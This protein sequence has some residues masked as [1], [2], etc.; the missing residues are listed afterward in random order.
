V[1]NPPVLTPAFDPLGIVAALAFVG[2]L[3]YLFYWMFHVPPPLP[4]EVVQAQFSFSA[5][6]RIIV[7]VSGTVASDRAIEL[8]SRI[9]AAQR[10]E[11]VP[12]FVVEV[13]LTLGLDASLPVQQARASEVL[14]RAR[15]LVAVHHLPVRTRLVKQRSLAEGVIRVAAEERADAIVMGMGWKRGVSRSDAATRTVLE[16]LRR[17]TCEVIIARYPAIE[18]EGIQAA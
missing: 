17:A 16:L 7:P 4:R 18:E 5:L 8:A 10:A 12:V 1:A 14:E 6:Q 11:I 15:L 13:P 3:G 2:S 9:G